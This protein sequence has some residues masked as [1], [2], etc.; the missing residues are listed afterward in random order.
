MGQA[1]SRCCQRL[2]R[3]FWSAGAEIEGVCGQRRGAVAPLHM[4]ALP[5]AQFR[6]PA[7]AQ[8]KDGGDRDAGGDRLAGIG[9]G[10]RLQESDAAVGVDEQHVEWN[11]RV[12]HPEAGGT[13]R[14]HREQH[15][16][17]RG[18]RFPEHEAAFL[19]LFGERN[20]HREAVRASGGADGEGQGVDLPGRGG[21]FRLGSVR[22]AC[23]QQRCEKEKGKARH[24]R[25]VA[26]LCG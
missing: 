10:V 20:L 7:A 2:A 15:A 5:D 23:G 9:G 22:G 19:L 13:R 1:L 17:V 4:V 18:D 6:R 26:Q 24:D 11:Q 3:R 21:V 14:V 25:G 12:L 8:L 16:G